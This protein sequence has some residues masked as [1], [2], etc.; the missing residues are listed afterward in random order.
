[1]LLQNMFSLNLGSVTCKVAQLLNPAA[2]TSMVGAS[3]NVRV[4][5]ISPA[6][7]VLEIR[8]GCPIS[9]IAATYLLIMRAIEGGVCIDEHLWDKGEGGGGGTSRIRKLHKA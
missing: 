8:P 3:S 2:D 5:C 6:G 9:S 4:T 7:L 1:M